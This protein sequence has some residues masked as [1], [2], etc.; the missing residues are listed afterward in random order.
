MF[1]SAKLK[2]ALFAG[3]GFVC[4]VGVRVMTDHCEVDEQPKARLTM[5]P[6]A[7]LRRFLALRTDT[8]GDEFDNPEKLS[9]QNL[10]PGYH[11]KPLKPQE[12]V[13]KTATHLLVSPTGCIF[14]ALFGGPRL[15]FSND[16][17]DLGE[18]WT[19]T[20]FLETMNQ[21]CEDFDFENRNSQYLAR[22]QTAF[23]WYLHLVE[24]ES[25]DYE[26]HGAIVKDLLHYMNDLRKTMRHD[27]CEK[28]MDDVLKAYYVHA[29]LI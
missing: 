5:S 6:E 20:K 1:K 24:D 13:P 26:V 18:A 23:G 28:A 12:D 19:K 2:F 15:R 10:T 8:A 14:D 7:R 9:R 25:D 21:F 16:D 22:V 11:P 29:W 3:L 27:A 17:V 4:A